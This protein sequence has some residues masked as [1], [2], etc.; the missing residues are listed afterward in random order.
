M[1]FSSGIFLFQFLPFFLLVYF[2]TPYKGKNILALLGSLFFY[3]WGGPEF[4]LWLLISITI[5]YFLTLAIANTEDKSKKKKLLFLSLLSNVG[6]LLY[7][8]YANFFVDNTG[9]LMSL[10]GGDNSF[11]ES[12]TPV[13]LP[14]GISFFTFQ[15]ISYVIDIYRGNAK[16]LKN[17]VDCTL[18]IMLFPQLIAGPIVRYKDVADQ[19]VDRRHNLNSQERLDG[20]VRFVVGLSKKM[21]IANQLGSMVDNELGRLGSVSTPEAW[22]I[23]VSYSFQIYFDFSGYSDMAIGIGKMMGFKFPENFNIPYV[24]Q[25]ITEFWQRWHITLGSWMRDYLYI[26]LGGNRVSTVRLYVNLIVVFLISGFWHGA[27]WNF[28]LWGGFHGFF[29]I[30]DRI[31]LKNLLGK[32]GT[33]PSVIITYV[34]VLIGWAIFRIEDWNE[35]CGMLR[36]MFGDSIN[37]GIDIYLTSKFWSILVLAI[38]FS[39]LPLIWCRPVQWLYGYEGVERGNLFLETLRILVVVILMITCL[40]EVF[41]S[42]FNPFIYFRF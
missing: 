41:A 27:S 23:I 1:V 16:V 37:S 15:K 20:M 38:L 11:I 40:S 35:L 33:L 42:G 10:F 5:D 24:S 26:P 13:V 3:A 21:L 14:I 28:L 31:F 7:F 9:L 6:V 39:F 25:S 2:L 22:L 36:I 4:L 34:I 18:Y 17:W 19:M 32:I 12:W 29:L 8:K 30:L